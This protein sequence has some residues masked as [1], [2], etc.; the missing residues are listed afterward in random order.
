MAR[1]NDDRAI[2]TDVKN[3]IRD[4]NSFSNGLDSPFKNK[5]ANINI[6]NK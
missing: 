6:T 4:M 5:L 1:E 3:A 2:I